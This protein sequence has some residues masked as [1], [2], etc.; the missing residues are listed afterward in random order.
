[1]ARKLLFD[2]CLRASEKYKKIFIRRTRVGFVFRAFVQKKKRERE[3]TDE[4]YVVVGFDKK[5]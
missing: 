2:F 4:D 3:K 5:N 1:M